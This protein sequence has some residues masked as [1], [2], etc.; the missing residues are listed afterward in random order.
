MEK[1]HKEFENTGAL[2]N[3]KTELLSSSS[4][5]LE[6]EQVEE[7]SNIETTIE[8]EE[9]VE[10]KNPLD[11]NFNDDDEISFN[12]ESDNEE[13]QPTLSTEQEES[14]EE[15][16]DND[17]YIDEIVKK[18]KRTAR[19]KK[20]T[21][22]EPVKDNVKKRKIQRLDPAHTDEMIKK[23]IPMGC[24]LCI[25]VG[26]NFTDIVKHFR[27]VHPNIRPY[28]MCCDKKLSKRFFLA[29]HAFKHE[30]PNC[31]R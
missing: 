26:S 4:I 3:I 30:D 6:E 20:D 25:F 8:I 2:S 7:Q 23:H 13:F 27:S 1:A 17:K 19:K 31:F 22:L 29:Q 5:K 16:E 15:E 9:N 14:T 10:I 12:D 24:N 21:N 28:V 18:K 11:E